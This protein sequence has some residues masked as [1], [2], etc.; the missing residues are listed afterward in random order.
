[1]YA[2]F[3]WFEEKI[4]HVESLDT[5]LRKLHASVEA[6]VINRREL[7]NLTAGVSKSAAMLSSCEDHNSLSR[8]LS[9]LADT[10]EKV[11]NL[12]IDQANTD[13]FVLSEMLKDY[14]GLI[15]AVKDAFHERTKV[16][17]YWQHSQQMLT[18][19]RESKAKLELNGRTDKLELAGREVLE[20]S[21]NKYICLN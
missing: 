1:M 11:E 7:G 8:V 19:K 21:N 4:Q 14:V 17:Q 13:F 9:Q 20:V 3:Q 18:K 2:V 15:G 12:H 10:E 5:Q 6:L 16:F